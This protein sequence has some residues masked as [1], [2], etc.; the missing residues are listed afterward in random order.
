MANQK[1][2]I[3]NIT[4]T[5]LGLFF[6]GLGVFAMD[7]G[8]YRGNPGWVFWLCYFGMIIIGGATIIRNSYLILSQINILTFPLLFW[9][10]DFIHFLITKQSLWEITD[11]FF[12]EMT[13]AARIIS[14][15]HLFLIPLGLLALYLIKINK[16]G[17]WKLS[18]VQL[19]IFFILSRFFTQIEHNVNCVFTSCW[20][21]FPSD[22]WH[23]VR[24]FII[25]SSMIIITHFIITHVPIF[26]KKD[27]KV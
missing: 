4:L 1:K 26:K 7:Y 8:I 15:E 23:P 13:T 18:L 19:T 21:M 10:I 9:N 20:P 3:K 11:Y 17:A 22:A 25:F 27:N 12:D 5:L 24:W 14:F 2:K 16:K 6:I